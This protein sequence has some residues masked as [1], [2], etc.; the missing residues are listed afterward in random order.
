MLLNKKEAELQEQNAELQNLE[1]QLK[2]KKEALHEQLQMQVY[3]LQ[4]QVKELQ[5]FERQLQQENAKLEQENT[6][7]QQQNANIKKDVQELQEKNSKIQNL[8]KKLQHENKE[9]LKE[10]ESCKQEF[11]ALEQENLQLQADMEELQKENNEL[12]K[13]LKRLKQN[14]EECKQELLANQKKKDDEIKQLR[15]MRAPNT[16]AVTPQFELVFLTISGVLVKQ[17]RCVSAEQIASVVRLCMCG[18]ALMLSSGKK[19]VTDKKLKRIRKSIQEDIM[20]PLHDLQRTIQYSSQ[21]ELLQILDDVCTD[22]NH[23]DTWITYINE[24]AK[25]KFICNLYVQ[26]IVQTHNNPDS[27]PGVAATRTVVS[28]TPVGSDRSYDD[29]SD[30]SSH[31]PDGGD[32]DSEEA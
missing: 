29:A 3:D 8:Y 15:D 23:I 20:K 16:T 21:V 4:R 25:K 5:S 12:L 6:D 13:N 11:E 1:R 14:F 27:A 18:V 7:L 24:V 19:E 28:G 26:S 17:G 2:Q 31:D 32:T 22:V 30:G 9:L 10:F